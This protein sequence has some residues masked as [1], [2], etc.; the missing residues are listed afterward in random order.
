MRYFEGSD[1]IADVMVRLSVQITT[2][3]R[4]DP[5]LGDQAGFVVSQDNPC[6]FC[7]GAQRAFLR[8]LGMS[9]NRISRLEQDSLTGDFTAPERAA[10]DFARRISQSKP[11]VEASELTALRDNGFDDD[12]IVEL[13][14]SI[15]MHLF[16]NRMSTFIALP[17]V[18]WNP[19]LINGGYD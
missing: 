6:R 11:L 13:T 18:K 12:D 5:N 8:V 10:L 7:F 14:G 1:W 19:Y 17:P 16:L 15:G 9:E 3:V 2:A 4:I